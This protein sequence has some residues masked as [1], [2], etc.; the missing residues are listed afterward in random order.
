MQGVRGYS[1]LVSLVVF[2]GSLGTFDV[3]GHSWW[4]PGVSRDFV[5]GPWGVREKSGTPQGG[6][7]SLKHN[8][9]F[10]ALS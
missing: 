3:L 6:W 1:F 8:L 9:I 5:E 2:A 4:V 7:K 10:I